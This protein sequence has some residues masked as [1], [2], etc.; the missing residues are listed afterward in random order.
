MDP[1]K[2]TDCLA[3]T[4]T[5]ILN[6]VIDWATA[7]RATQNVLWIHGLAGSGKSTL[8]TTLANVFRE[9][10][11]L[12]AFLFFARDVTERS[13][14]TTV[15]R[16]LAYQLGTFHPD[17]GK[18]IAASI[19]STPSICLSPLPFQFRRLLIDPLSS[20]PL[21]TPIVFVLD[22]LDQCGTPE[23]RESLMTVL[24]EQSDRLP[25]AIRFIFTSRA[26]S[27]ICR[28]FDL[29]PHILTRELDITSQAN[30]DD[31]SSY[32]RHGM[33]IV[34]ANNKRLSL[35]ADWPG[36]NTIREL[37][38]R[39]S[40][41]F[42]WASTALEFIDGYNPRVCLDTILKGE[43][44]SAAQAAL[45]S[46]Y[47]TAL[48]SEG[49][50]DNEDFVAD[51]RAIIGL[52][53]VAETPLSSSAIDR[54]LGKRTS[55]PA[56]HTVSKLACVLQQTPTV[57]VLHS[58]F[59]DF[60]LTKSRCG[61]DIWWFDP[62]PHH[63]SLAIQCLHRLNAVLKYNVFGLTL[64][65]DVP[66]RG[67]SA[68][69]SFPEDISYACMFWIEHICAIKDSVES[70]FELLKS[71]LT[72]HLLHWFEAMSILRRSRDTIASLRSLLIWMTNNHSDHHR[73]SKFVRDALRF[74]QIFA[75][76]IEEH[77]LLVYRTALPFAPAASAVYKTFHD[78]ALFPFISGAFHQSWSALLLVLQ[79]HEE[80]V[81]SVAVSPDG[82]KIISG[83]ADKT[84][85]VWDATS[86]AEVL[87]ALRHESVVSSV[88]FSPDGRRIVSGS[89]DGAI[90]VWDA[91]S[92][93][94]VLPGLRW[95]EEEVT[96]VACSRIGQI[97]SSSYDD[98]V[99]IWNAASGKE[100]FSAIRG[101]DK[102]VTAVVYSPDGAR[103]ASGSADK[104]V[105]VWDAATGA[106]LLQ[107]MRG[108]QKAVTSVAFSPDGNHIVSGSEDKTIRVWDAI[109]GVDVLPALRGHEKEVTSVAFSPHGAHIAS[110][111]EDKTVRVW[112]RFSG[113]EVLTLRGHDQG[114]TSVAFSPDATCIVSGSWDHTVR[115][116]YDDATSD[117][118]VPLTMRGPIYRINSVAFSAH[119]ALVVSGSDDMTVR[120]WDTTSGAEVIP[121]LRGH[122]RGVWSVA[123]SPDG[124]H[125]VSGSE[126]KTVRVWNT[127]SGREMLTLQGHTDAVDLVSFSDDGSRIISR[128]RSETI[129]WDATS[130]HRLAL[131]EIP[132]PV[133]LSTIYAIDGWIVD[134][135][136]DKTLCKLPTILSA[137]CS[138]ACGRS[139]AAGTSDGRLVVVHF[140]PLLFIG[141]GGQ[142]G[143][144][145]KSM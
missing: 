2:L 54:L 17:I 36:E 67:P 60:L 77:P 48:E 121:A 76:S 81:T 106:K 84:I 96:S 144:G 78:A 49:I 127:S 91:A 136:T 123:F 65:K 133:S 93:A 47:E 135:A 52:V 98:T 95:H 99:R 5:G 19:E 102:A 108:H 66:Y 80:R 38:E 12:G 28:A 87:P 69:E 53:L 9:Q 14:P 120:V 94:D 30:T 58:S 4:R 100:V 118:E 23:E 115:V 101:H 86:G 56:D 117:T 64:S 122:D 37:T 88:T 137:T 105:R 109:S 112:N 107:A 27:D 15:V 126:D 8:A 89:W 131:N 145:R 50:W 63:Q 114:V 124:T 143:K 11:R 71:F 40:G 82:T 31:I 142:A 134:S 33:S 29:Q 85:L 34:R 1:S 22:A 42:I 97:V 79:G 51:F 138:A 41:L 46:L 26:E 7:P 3:D 119:G 90:R 132:N 141:S 44:A 103:I 83:S 125:I 45:D 104:T 72:R 43:V 113:T 140:P 18:R 92:G 61:R 39:A 21:R 128:S 73:I 24:S 13:N 32:F 139:L 130:G 62:A 110:G 68:N 25:P 116:W 6:F 16:T 59:A 74:A 70:T 55:C 10:G 111:S 57:R 75:S 129:S 20:F 35:E